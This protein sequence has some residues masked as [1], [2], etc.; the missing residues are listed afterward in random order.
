MSQELLNGGG[1]IIA[2]DN[3]TTRQIFL[4]A[5]TYF[6]GMLLKLIAAIVATADAGNTGD[7]TVTAASA[8]AGVDPGDYV[9][10]CTAAVANGGVFKLEDPEGNVIASDLR[11]DVGS[12]V[13]TTFKIAGITFTVT[14]GASDFAADD[15]FTLTVATTVTGSYSTNG[16][17]D[18][19]YN[20][21]DN[22]GEG[23]VLSAPA[24]RDCIVGGDIAHSGLVDDSGAQLVLNETQIAGLRRDGFFVKEY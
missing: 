20:G 12:G 9:L 1:K 23:E 3:V 8:E 15:F 13:A 19:V 5:G 22:E 2:G 14:D 24:A 4:A 6:K 11:M 17:F 18:A 7:G 16:P 21:G 10:T